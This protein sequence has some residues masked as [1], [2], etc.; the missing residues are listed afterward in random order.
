MGLGL[1]WLCHFYYFELHHHDRAQASF[2][3]AIVKLVGITQSQYHCSAPTSTS[4]IVHSTSCA[5]TTHSLLIYSLGRSSLACYPLLPPTASA[6][7]R[8]CI[9]T[10]IKV[11]LR[12]AMCPPVEVPQEVR[13]PSSPPAQPLRS[14]R[15]RRPALHHFHFCP[16]TAP[17]SNWLDHTHLT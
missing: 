8:E 2:T 12:C 15:P 11:R 1:G 9:R 7:P 13:P 17:R 5:T 3:I 10:C 16:C 4:N 14:S 6:Y